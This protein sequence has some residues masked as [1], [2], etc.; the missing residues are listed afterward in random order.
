MNPT[1]N[2]RIDIGPPMPAVFTLGDRIHVTYPASFRESLQDVWQQTPLSVAFFS[3]KNVAKIQ[4]GIQDG[5]Y[6]MSNGKFRLGMKNNEKLIEIMRNIFRENCIHATDNV[7]RQ[8]NSLN[9]IVLRQTV[10]Q[11]FREADGYMKYRRDA[12]SIARPIDR[13]IV[14]RTTRQL[15]FKDRF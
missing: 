14:T 3:H 5:V 13:P 2:G 9:N 8:L 15:T 12:G 1:Q 7:E 4:K 10:T 11:V 6:R